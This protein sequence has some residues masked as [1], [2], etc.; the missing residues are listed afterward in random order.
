[1]MTEY[2]LYARD[3]RRRVDELSD[4]A[5]LIEN[6]LRY[7][8]AVLPVKKV[9]KVV[10]VARMQGITQVSIRQKPWLLPN[11]GESDYED[12]PT[13]WNVESVM[14]WFDRYGRDPQKAKADWEEHEREAMRKAHDGGNV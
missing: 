9:L 2:D 6:R 11:F 1:M 8:I 3:L 14:D 10:D 12:K 5:A 13:R 4:Q 7:L